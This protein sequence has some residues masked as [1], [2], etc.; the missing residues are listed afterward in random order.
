MAE[1]VVIV[2]AAGQGRM[3]IDIIERMTA[4]GAADLKVRGVYDDAP[5]DDDLTKLATRSVPYL[6][7][8]QKLIDTADTPNVVV[9]IGYPQPRRNVAQ[10]LQQHDFT[11]PVLVDPSA[12]LGTDLTLGA[13]VVI[14]AGANVSTATTVG[15]FVHLNPGVIVGHDVTLG[16]HAAI[17]PGA[18]ISGN[19]NVGA[20]A[21]V[22]AGAMILQGLEIGPEA[23]VGAGAVVTKPVSSKT[24]VK[25]IPAR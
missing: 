12:T 21:L 4:S 25:G 14:G 5:S 10:R 20:S 11:Y 23:T 18:I 6:G 7:T 16:D 24:T 9:G 3:C 8:I 15:D 1:E 2:G 22:G 13:G 17:N 19:V